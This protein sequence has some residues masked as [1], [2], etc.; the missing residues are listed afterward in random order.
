[1]FFSGFHKLNSDHFGPG[2]CSEFL[3]SQSVF[4]SFKDFL[5]WIVVSGE[6]ILAVRLFFT[7]KLGFPLI[8]FGIFTTSVTLLGFQQFMAVLWVGAFPLLSKKDEKTKVF[9]LIVSV[10]S[11]M[12]SF[13]SGDT[14]LGISL[15]SSAI[16]WLLILF[17]GPSPEVPTPGKTAVFVTVTLVTLNCLTPYLG[18][19]SSG[20]FNMYSNLRIEKERTNHFIIRKPL[21]LSR[22]LVETVTVLETNLPRYSGLLWLRPEVPEKIL[23]TELHK[24]R[25]EGFAATAKFIRNGETVVLDSPEEISSYIAGFPIFESHFLG[26]SM[27]TKGPYCF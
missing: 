18:W 7:R 13:A 4:G 25:R 26:F 16:I 20:S 8:L 22:N 2:N 17:T 23:K 27:T 15:M 12:I 1:M 3:A 9:F 11:A 6:L 14:Y 10:L 21:L 19:K 24:A 5:P